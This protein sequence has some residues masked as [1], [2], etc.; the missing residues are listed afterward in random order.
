[1]LRIAEIR[2]DKKISQSVLAKKVGVEG[3]TLSKYEKG[4]ISPNAD[5]LLKMANAL[6]V[7]IEMLFDE[8]SKHFCSPNDQKIELI[9]LITKTPNT[10]MDEL[11]KYIKKFYK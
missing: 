11:Y 2:K 7:D 4:N 3:G 10:K 6:G 1:M 9:E 5:T 8:N